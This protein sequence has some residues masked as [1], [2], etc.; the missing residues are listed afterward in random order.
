MRLIKRAVS[1]L[2]G[3]LI[4]CSCLGLNVYAEP[5]NDDFDYE[6]SASAFYDDIMQIPEWQQ[7]KSRIIRGEM[8][9][10]PDDILA[11]MTT[12]E[13]ADA[14]ADY[15][16]FDIYAFD[17]TQTGVEILIDHFN[18]AKE[19]M[20]RPDCASVL[21][22]KYEAK[23][24]YMTADENIDTLRFSYIEALLTQNT[25]IDQMDESEVA[26][27]EKVILNKYDQKLDFDVYGEFSK[28][29]P[30][31]LLSHNSGNVDLVSF[32]EEHCISEG[33]AVLGF[34]EDSINA[35]YSGT[36]STSNGTAVSV[37]VFTS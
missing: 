21:L 3:L 2:C 25:V 14:V 32:A 37:T 8:L 35:S 15:P 29:L 28:E 16:F 22:D 30:F 7:T 1:C 20:S 33:S 17:N 19:L 24:V 9:E 23:P 36:V 11:E 27:L 12:S 5:L 4:G 13:L 6:F 26:K 18:G 34:Q 10:L 31:K